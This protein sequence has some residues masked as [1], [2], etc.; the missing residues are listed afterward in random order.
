MC[1]VQTMR[2]TCL[3]QTREKIKNLGIMTITNLCRSKSE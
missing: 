3:G 2:K 1:D